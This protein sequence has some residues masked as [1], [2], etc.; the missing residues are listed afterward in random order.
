MGRVVELLEPHSQNLGHA[1]SAREVVPR[2]LLEVKTLG[3]TGGQVDYEAIDAQLAS[4]IG[5]IFG[6]KGFGK[7]YNAEG[8]GIK[9]PMNRKEIDKLMKDPTGEVGLWAAIGERMQQIAKGEYRYPWVDSDIEFA[10]LGYTELFG[11]ENKREEE[12]Q[13]HG[14]SWVEFGI[15]LPGLGSTELL[16]KRERWAGFLLGPTGK[17]KLRGEEGEPEKVRI[18]SLVLAETDHGIGPVA[19]YSDIDPTNSPQSRERLNFEFNHENHGAHVRG[20][21]FDLR[22]TAICLPQG[23]ISPSGAR[24]GA[25]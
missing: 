23:G 12:N 15:K 24:S 18:T 20:F 19:V 6:S 17:Q 10:G 25:N 2:R 14:P 16:G 13:P 5:D 1:E 9:G 11:I 7:R 21:P 8:L 4:A 22:I 3:Y